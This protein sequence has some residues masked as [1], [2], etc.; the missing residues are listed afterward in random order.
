[1]KLED[2][3]QINGLAV[4]FAVTYMISYVTRINFGAI[5]AE[6]EIATQI[7]RSLLSMALT[8]SFITYG[9]GQIISGVCGDKLSPKKL[10]SCGLLATIVMN[11]CIPLCRDPYQ[12][13]AVWCVNGFAQAFMW[14][15]IVRMMTELLTEE[16]YRKVT[17]KVSWGSSFGTILVYFAAPLIISLLNWKWVF[18]FSAGC[19]VIMLLVW[20]KLALDIAP[21]AKAQQSESKAVSSRVLFT[22]LMLAS[23]A[24]ILLQGM[25][26]DGVTT[27]MPT[28][29]ADTYQLSSVVSILTGVVLPIFSIFSVQVAS[30]LYRKVLPNPL[31]CA[32]A[33]FAIGAVSAVGVSAF[34]GKAVTLSVLSSA[35]LTGSMHGINLMLNSMIPTFFEKYGK[36]STA[37]GMLNACSYIGSAISTYGIAVLSE[38]AGW[39]VTVLL[40]IGIAAAGMV[41]CFLCTKP[42]EREFGRG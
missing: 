8:G 28:Y 15:P 31:L 30:R 12:M 42:W 10:I 7:P 9:A 11:L 23:M 29:I 26:K 1:M 24:A 17:V 40:W 3:R 22:P 35:L 13:L 41:I 19:G 37:S 39:G 16:D 32:G 4:L 27:W 2:K 18:I 21:A 36:V 34:S 5:I 25:L 14:P 38:T 20:N 6:M 33:F